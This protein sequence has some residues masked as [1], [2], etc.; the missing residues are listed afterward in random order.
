MS[1][2]LGVPHSEIGGPYRTSPVVVF[3]Q[4]LTDAYYVTA[5]ASLQDTLEKIS[6]SRLD[7]KSVE[8]VTRTSSVPRPAWAD[9]P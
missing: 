7:Q 1:V 3:F 4:A 9:G 8:K 5:A 6:T 2:V